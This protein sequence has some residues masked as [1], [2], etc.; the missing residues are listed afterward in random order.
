MR[1][2]HNLPALNAHRNLGI[3]NTYQAKSQEKLSSG[4]RINRAADDAAGLAISEGM[5]SQIRGLNQATRNSQDAISLIQTAEGALSET[6]SILH[7]MRELAV[8]AANDTYTANDRSELQKEIEQLKSEID[9][10]ANTTSF[11][12]KTLL[13]G[14]ASAIASTDNANT[15]V[16]MR[17]GLTELGV[18]SAGTYRI[19]MEMNTAGKTQVQ[20]S[21]TM[22]L[23]SD[24]VSGSTVVAKAGSVASG[25]TQLRNVKQFYDASGKFLLDQQQNITLV[26]GDGKTYT[27][28]ISADDT[29]DEV[30][31]KFN[32]AIGGAKG[33]NQTALVSGTATFATYNV[34]SGGGAMATTNNF[35]ISSAIAGEAGKIN[36]IAD[37]NLL[38]AFGLTE[39]QK[40]TET[41]YDV[42]VTNTTTGNT[43]ASG[44]MVQ[45]N[46]ILG[47]VHKNVDV[48]VDSAAG[49]TAALGAGGVASGVFG[50]AASATDFTT[51]VHLV[52]SSQ[53]F[54]I[55][56]NELQNMSAAIGNMGTA[57]LGVDNIMVTDIVSAGRSI[58]KLDAALTKVSAQRASLGAIQNRL[59]HTINNLGVA[60]ENITASESRIRDVDMAAEM[61][62][63]TKLNVLSQAATAML[64][65]AN[66][67]PQQVLQLLGR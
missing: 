6:H 56:A 7:R 47:L 24:V 66:Q 4:F 45:G 52:D 30:A 63:F 20:L 22:Q 3:N 55:G 8:Q 60:A 12:N 9:R 49:V 67:Q 1:I 41:T 32:N 62:E 46:N 10:I 26:E 14:S 5:R 50:I 48:R 31:T 42:T 11:N 13:D 25:G 40:A 29:L 37:Q 39:F 43:V 19:D 57:S 15:K 64:A 18:S 65:Q 53:V 16:F 17:G 28:S 54:Q 34:T 23:Q 2:N 51:T 33:F 38:K 21:N 44:A 35:V 61:M 27:F 58:S 59:E 36:M